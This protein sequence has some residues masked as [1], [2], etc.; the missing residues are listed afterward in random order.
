MS[1]ISDDSAGD[2]SAPDGVRDAFCDFIEERYH[3]WDGEFGEEVHLRRA[4][5]LDPKQ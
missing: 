5:S 2:S 3:E 1:T 4:V